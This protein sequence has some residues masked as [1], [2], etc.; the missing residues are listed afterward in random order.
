MT[1][2]LPPRI[3]EAL[4]N[5]GAEF[6]QPGHE[7]LKNMLFA[8][9]H[10]AEGVTLKLDLPPPVTRDAPLLELMEKSSGDPEAR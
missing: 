3:E 1:I 9:C 4:N 8:A 6:G 2:T 10:A 5:K 7:Y